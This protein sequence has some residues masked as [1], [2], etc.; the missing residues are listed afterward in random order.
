[1]QTKRY[2]F[3]GNSFTYQKD[4]FSVAHKEFVIFLQIVCL[5]LLVLTFI[6]QNNQIVRPISLQIM[7]LSQSMPPTS[8]TN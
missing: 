1:M 4:D 5:L 2:K 7:I 8:T 3:K 6:T